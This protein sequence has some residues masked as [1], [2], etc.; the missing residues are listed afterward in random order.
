VIVIAEGAEDG[1]IPSERERM[2]AKL[3]GNQVKDESGNVKSLV[4]SDSL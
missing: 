4:S 3:G 1:M 2:R